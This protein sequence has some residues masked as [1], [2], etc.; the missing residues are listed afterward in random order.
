MKSGMYLV[1]IIRLRVN[2]S[3]TNRGDSQ[4]KRLVEI[5]E[6]VHLAVH[7]PEDCEIPSAGGCPPGGKFQVI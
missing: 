2:H 7:L 5:P 3:W 6:V 1:L 4:R